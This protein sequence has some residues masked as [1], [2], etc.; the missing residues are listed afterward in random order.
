LRLSYLTE[1]PGEAESVLGVIAFGQADSQRIDERWPMAW[2]DLPPLRSPVL[3]EVWQTD[4]PIAYGRD[5]DIAFA[6]T[7]DLLFGA[8]TAENTNDLAA[9]TAKAYERI[10]AFVARSG[11]PHFLRIWNYFPAITAQEGGMERYH[12]FSLGRAQA[13]LAQG[14]Q[15]ENA[16]AACAIGT[17]SGP[18]TILFL[19]AKR[20]GQ[21][22]EN[23]R[24]ISAYRYPAQYGPKSPIFSRALVASAAGG[25]VLFIS[26]TASIVGH[27]SR[28]PDDFPA[29][30]AETLANLDALKTEA[31]KAGLPE[32]GRFLLKAYIR[33]GAGVGAVEKAV[34]IWLGDTGAL[35]CLTGDICRKE[36]LVEIEGYYA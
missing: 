20:E 11:F 35:V 2:I 12:A 21:P 1:R 5:Q 36:L 19:A 34:K 7:Q 10:F 31:R 18:L 8:L 3:Y 30:L 9:L 33:D 32:G 23:P 4:A 17:R 15:V 22:I 13:F 24:Q 29:Q 6:K 27:E 28:H 25:P 16:P 26:G 14:S